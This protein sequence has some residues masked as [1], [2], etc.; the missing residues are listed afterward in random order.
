MENI[1]KKMIDLKSCTLVCA[2]GKNNINLIVSSILNNISFGEIIL[3]KN[4]KSIKDYNNFI[5]KKLG[6]SLKTEHCL[7]VQ[8]DGYPI[9][10]KAWNP[11]W[12]SLDYIGAP[13]INQPWSKDLSVGN[14]GFSLRSKRLLK[15]VSLLKY[16]GIEPE[17]AFICRTNGKKL[18]EEGYKF[19]T[20][21]E[22]YSFSVE[23]SYYKEQFG[24]HGKGTIML[25]K[26][27]GIF[28]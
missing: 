4:I 10:Y 5:I 3:E 8:H 20:I 23:D 28:K 21:E 14:G 22:A 26:K 6:E 17:D 25:N 7:I 15:R 11:G 9:N 1:S 27:L 18:K 13:W 16:E 12:L 19:A 24:F 2:D